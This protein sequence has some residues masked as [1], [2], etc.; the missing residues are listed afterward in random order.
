DNAIALPINN[1]LS[2]IAGINIEKTSVLTDADGDTSTSIALSNITHL[3][4]EDDSPVLNSIQDSIVANQVSS[5]SGDI[6]V[7]FGTD[8]KGHIAITSFTDLPGITEHLSN[9][10]TVLTA[11]IDG[12]GNP[13]DPNDDTVLYTLTLNSNDTYTFDLVN[14]RPP[15]TE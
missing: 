10:G 5:T 8:G 12:S 1:A 15:V 6:N 11:T 13:L 2:S 9:D 7:D 14:L 3:V 4:I